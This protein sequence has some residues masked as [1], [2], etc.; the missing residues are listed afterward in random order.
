MPIWPLYVINLYLLLFIGPG[1]YIDPSHT[2]NCYCKAR[3]ETEKSVVG[4][5]EWSLLR[6]DILHIF[7]G[8]IS[9][10]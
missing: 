1:G 2:K 8:G 7:V 10:E 4:R 9:N 3:F 5:G 6:G